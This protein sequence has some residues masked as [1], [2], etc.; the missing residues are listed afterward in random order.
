MILA[1]VLP[2][3]SCSSLQPDPALLIATTAQ[4][5]TTSLWASPAGSGTSCTAGS[6]WVDSNNRPFGDFNGDVHYTQQDG[7]RAVFSFN[8]T[9]VEFVTEVSND[10]GA[11]EVKVDGVPRGRIFNYS[12]NFAAQQTVYRLHGLAIGDHTISLTKRDATFRVLQ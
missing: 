10:R 2:N 7:D 12:A 1:L 3:I 9:G 6:G 8:G 5:L 4:P 11:I